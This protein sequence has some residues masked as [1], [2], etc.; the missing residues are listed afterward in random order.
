MP[1]VLASW[2][3]FLHNLLASTFVSDGLQAKP[4][5]EFDGVKA[6]LMD[7]LPAELPTKDELAPLQPLTAPAE[8]VAAPMSE[9]QLVDSLIGLPWE[10][11]INKDARQEWARMDRPFRSA[12]SVLTCL[13]VTTPHLF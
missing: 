12:T 10:F 11:I 3:R 13:A 5:A 7:H 6:A 2:C 9:E 4:G 8:E 1:W